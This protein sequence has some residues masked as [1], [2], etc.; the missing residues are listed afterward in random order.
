MR[1]L[2]GLLAIATAWVLLP[3]QLHA[4]SSQ[5][6]PLPVIT[7]TVVDRTHAPVTRATVA[8]TSPDGQSQTIASDERG[9]FR[10]AVAPGVYTVAIAVPGFRTLSRS[11]HVT[12][13]ESLEFVLEIEA[14]NEQVDVSADAPYQSGVIT[15]ATKTPVR[16]RDVPQ[17]ITV[18]TKDLIQ[19]QSMS[20]MA[21]TAA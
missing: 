12:T 3:S 10:L 20:S 13:S 19:D 1:R 14:L 6:A 2:L 18:V 5:S 9:A 21:R 7:G 8:I 16:L 17:S 15:S 4:S 11:L